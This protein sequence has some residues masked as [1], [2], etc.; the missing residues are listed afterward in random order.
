MEMPQVKQGH[1]LCVLCIYTFFYVWI[2]AMENRSQYLL[3][4]HCN[5][6]KY[7]SDLN[8]LDEHLRNIHAD[9]KSL[10]CGH[11]KKSILYR[12]SLI[13]HIQNFHIFN[14]P[15]QSREVASS[16]NSEVSVAQGSN[17]QVK[18]GEETNQSCLSCLHCAQCT[19]HSSVVDLKNHLSAFHDGLS[20]YKC[21]QCRKDFLH[22]T[23]LVRHIESHIKQNKD[24]VSVDSSDEHSS[25]SDGVNNDGGTFDMED[26]GVAAGNINPD[27]EDISTIPPQPA[28][29]MQEEIAM[30]LLKLR[31]SGNLTNTSIQMIIDNVSILLQNIM[32]KAKEDTKTFL[33]STE[34]PP[35]NAQNFLSSI[36]HCNDMFNG[37]KSIEDQLD[38]YCERFGL[39]VPEELF[40]DTRVE[41]RFDRKWRMFLPKQVSET[42]QYVSLIQTLTLIVR[43]DYFRKLILSE[44]KSSDGV[45]RSYKDGTDF[46]NN[47]FLRKYPYALRIVLY[48][49]GLEIANA[50]GSKDVIHALGCFYISIQNLPPEE[51]SLLSSIFLLALCH[52]IDLKKPGA[53]KKVLTMFISELKRLQTDEGVE[54]DLRNGHKFIIRACL[55]VLT[56]DTLAAHEVLG[57]FISSGADKF[58]RVCLISKKDFMEDTTAIGIRRTQATHERHVQ[59]VEQRPA[60]ARLYGVKERSALFEVMRVPEDSVFDVFHDCVGV[61][62]MLIKLSLYEYVMVRKFFSIRKFNENINLFIIGKPDA[63]NRPSANLIRMKLYSAGHTL[64]QYGSQT[65]CLLRMFPFLISGVNENNKHLQL[66][67]LLQDIMKIGLLNRFGRE[68]HELFISP[69]RDNENDDGDNEEGEDDDNSEEED[70]DNDEE[71]G[72]PDEPAPNRRRGWTSKKLKKG[73]NKLHHLMHYAEQI[74]EKGPIIRHWCARCEGRHR[75]LRKHSAV[76]CNFK[77][78]PK[79]MARM[80]QLSTLSAFL[81]RNSPHADKVNLSGAVSVSVRHS[82]YTALLS[83]VGFQEDD[84]I[85]IVESAQVCGEEYQSGL[86]VMLKQEGSVQPVFAVIVDV[87]AN[88]SEPTQVF[89]VVDKCRNITLSANYNAYRIP[90]QFEETHVLVNVKSLANHRPIA[91]WCPI[92]SKDNMEFYLSPRTVTV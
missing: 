14:R 21:G 64:K 40:L 26:A 82:S 4:I 28:L 33:N 74:R 19:N 66:I 31:A 5:P 17:L 86:F 36:F 57:F 61:I 85:N 2:G 53:F 76:Q 49:D 45:Y 20:S 89:L 92:D 71:D 25:A 6:Y 59:E 73:I 88:T 58:C 12:R 68:F 18:R 56:T 7:L 83:D 15:Q 75:I 42:F 80:F 44:E 90:N 91:P 78:P 23:S 70:D 9:L 63:K 11:C 1:H 62:Q 22:K 27:S 46:A 77:N 55:V 13:R 8:D 79:T 60:A 51:S 41:N 84:F 52:A 35:E 3:C 24:G 47:R 87:I 81:A 67:F 32:L 50:L 65:F 30:F 43:N 72:D 48:Y 37:L 38:F 10:N 54:I 16:S 69:A 29:N 34:V 39:V